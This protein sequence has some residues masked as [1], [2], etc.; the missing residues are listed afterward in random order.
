MG[1]IFDILTAI[2]SSPEDKKQKPKNESIYSEEEMDGYGLTEEEKKEVRN[3][4]QNPWD[5]E[6]ENTEDGDYYDEDDK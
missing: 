3:G 4:N 2:S 5:F 1:L 6:E